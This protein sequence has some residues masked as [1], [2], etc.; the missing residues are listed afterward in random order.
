MNT[1]IVYTDKDLLGI[2]KIK[3]VRI[4]R[5]LIAEGKLQCKKVGR[6]YRYT[7]KHLSDF[8]NSKDF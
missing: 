5:A 4:L 2:L 8:L 6:Y 3:D 1:P 7:E